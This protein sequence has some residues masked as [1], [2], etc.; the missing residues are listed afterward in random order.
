[1]VCTW[2]P[3]NLVKYLSPVA[4]S[5]IQYFSGAGQFSDSISIKGI[6]SVSFEDSSYVIPITFSLKF[7]WNF[8]ELLLVCS[9][10]WFQ[11]RQDNYCVSPP[12]SEV[13]AGCPLLCANAMWPSTQ[14]V[15]VLSSFAEYRENISTRATSRATILF[16]AQLCTGGPTGKKLPAFSF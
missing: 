10:S 9:V 3:S 4:K 2:I 8:N 11:G 7:P 5:C 15:S 13:F 6:S 14:H 16:Q 1:M 12:E